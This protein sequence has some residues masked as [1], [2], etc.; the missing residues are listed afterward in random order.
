[1]CCCGFPVM[2]NNSIR[3]CRAIPVQI[4]VLFGLDQGAR[5]V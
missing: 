5:G 2:D 1:M 4:S 3:L